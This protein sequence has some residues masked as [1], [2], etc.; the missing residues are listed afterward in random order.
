MEKAIENAEKTIATL[1]DASQT[2][3]DPL[4]LVEIYKQLSQAQEKLEHLFTRWQEL[5]NKAKG[6]T[7]S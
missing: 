2:T 4:K 6:L 3:A 5:E 1:I 7:L